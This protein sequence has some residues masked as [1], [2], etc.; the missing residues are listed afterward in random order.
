MAS[1]ESSKTY[2]LHLEET[3]KGKEIETG[4]T[5]DVETD[6]VEKKDSEPESDGDD[7]QRNEQPETETK[8]QTVPPPNLRAITPL[9]TNE[10]KSKAPKKRKRPAKFNTASN[11]RTRSD[12]KYDKY[13]TA[14]NPLPEDVE[15]NMKDNNDEPLI[16]VGV[17]LEPDVK[18]VES[19]KK[20]SD[21]A[22]SKSST[23]T[24]KL[25][26]NEIKEV[27]ELPICDREKAI[28]SMRHYDVGIINKIIIA[29]KF[30]NSLSQKDNRQLIRNIKNE[31][32]HDPTRMVFDIMFCLRRLGEIKHQQGGTGETSEEEEEEHVKIEEAEEGQ[33]MGII[34]S[35]STSTRRSARIPQQTQHF[36]FT[37]STTVKV[38]EET[39]PTPCMGKKSTKEEVGKSETPTGDDKK[40]SS[41]SIRNNSA[42]LLQELKQK[43]TEL[44][45]HMNRHMSRI[46]ADYRGVTGN[47]T[48][49]VTELQTK[50]Q[51]AKRGQQ[52]LRDELR[53]AR[54]EQLR[55]R[56]E[57]D[58]SIEYAGKLYAKL[59]NVE[60]ECK[61][62][63][64]KVE[65]YKRRMDR[66]RKTVRQI[67][68]LYQNLYN[69][70]VYYHDYTFYNYTKNLVC[71]EDDEELFNGVYPAYMKSAPLKIGLEY[72][73]N[74]FHIKTP[75]AAYRTPVDVDWKIKCSQLRSLVANH[76]KGCIVKERHLLSGDEQLD[77]GKYS[78]GNWK[79]WYM[80]SDDDMEELP[81]NLSVEIDQEK[82]ASWEARYQELV[83][84]FNKTEEQSG[85]EESE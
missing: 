19:F 25:I 75:E 34:F 11:K 84:K 39:K 30:P 17:I 60:T 40:R 20:Q 24:L 4:E 8:L 68:S 9:K 14:M 7:Q 10:V 63:K 26:I 13:S 74:K 22:E 55:I 42:T 27:V 44:V 21:K 28:S 69:E 51:E 65:T 50:L 78:S 37:P 12:G 58:S 53:E 66:Y 70:A 57:T 38:K 71:S 76:G 81:E 54:G 36:S 79:P 85:E 23:N 43:E 48:E 67:D 31:S 2:R 29:N 3:K 72:S 73:K 45:D 47:L 62:L 77:V 61:G 82:Q 46:S 80:V 15:T 83:T 64:G 52:R 32:I 33:E 16:P 41:K 1:K 56:E 49:Q 59:T 35:T 6:D 18:E 5:D